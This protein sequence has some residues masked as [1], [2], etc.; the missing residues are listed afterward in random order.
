MSKG[1]DRMLGSVNALIQGDQTDEAV[2]IQQR[3]PWVW[4]P[5]VAA[6]II[7][8]LIGRSIGLPPVIGAGIGGGCL[9]AVYASLTKYYVLAS[10]GSSVYL[11]RSKAMKASAIEVL[12]TFDRPV[13]ITTVTSVIN[14][15]IRIDGE[16][17]ISSRAFRDRLATMGAS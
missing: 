12:K 8:A 4:L 13:E 1:R 11:C 16:E 5:A 10:A 2:L 17:Y 6:F 14:D 7:A 9:G 3:P 15:K